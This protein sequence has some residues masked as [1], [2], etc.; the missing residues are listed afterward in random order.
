[1]VISNNS[2]D[3]AVVHSSTMW[4]CTASSGSA[5]LGGGGEGEGGGGLG[6]GGGGEG[7][8]GGGLGLGGGGEGEG[9][10]GLGLGGGGEG[11]RGRKESWNWIRHATRHMLLQC[12]CAPWCEALH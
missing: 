6:L 5:D 8:G 9:G 7:E 4:Q 2:T 12:T 10:G 11:L 1:M 3:A